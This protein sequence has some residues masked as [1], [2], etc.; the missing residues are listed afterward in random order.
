MKTIGNGPRNWKRGRKGRAIV[1]SG[2]VTTLLI[3]A[4][5][6]LAVPTGLITLRK[7]AIVVDPSAPLYVQR[8]VDDLQHQIRLAVGKELAVFKSPARCFRM[9]SPP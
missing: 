7:G 6:A 2:L 5:P 4:L 1:R 8:A 3:A 9:R